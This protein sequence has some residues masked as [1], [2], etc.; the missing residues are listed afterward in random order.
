MAEAL[1]LLAIKRY[2]LDTVLPELSGGRAVV[3]GR[4]VDST[5]VCQAL[6]LHPGNP[7]A[8]LA[9]AIALLDLAASYRP[10][11]DLTILITDDAAQAVAR[12][13]QRDLCVFT[14]E[15]AAF[16][17]DAATLFERVAATD[18]ARYRVLD[19][20]NVDEH[21]AAGRIRAWI[22]DARTDLSCMC[23]PW[24]GPGARCMCCGHRARAAAPI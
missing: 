17:H 4:S 23:E 14:T 21:E 8:A 11:P 22:H 10:L 3:E 12:T 19:R 1:I 18:R 6:L 15:Q 2:D 24:Q 5:A 7:H 16:M 9:T 20:R 13:Q